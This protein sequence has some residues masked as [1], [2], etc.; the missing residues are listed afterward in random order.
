MKDDVETLR[1][2]IDIAARALA[3]IRTHAG[4][5]HS[6]GW[7]PAVAEAE[8]VSGGAVDHTPRS[9]DPRARRLFDRM[10]EDIS[11]FESEIVGYDRVMMALFTTRAERPD[12]TRGSTIS[13]AEFDRLRERQ[14]ARGDAPARLEPQPDHPGKR[15]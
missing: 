5:L 1:R 2:R 4:D 10:L 13:V 15:R 9:G 3:R 8:K 6:L 7:E 12:P 14:R 11:S